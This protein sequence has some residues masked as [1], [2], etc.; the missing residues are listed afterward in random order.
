MR[1]DNEAV[2]EK[3]KSVGMPYDDAFRTMMVK[4]RTLAIPFLNEMFHLSIPSDA[5][6]VAGSNELFTSS[7]SRRI[8][9]SNLRIAGDDTLYHTECESLPGGSRILI[10]LFEYDSSIAIRHA[11]IEGDTLYVTY[12]KTGV[13]YLRNSKSVND[14]MHMVIKAP[15]GDEQLNIDI[16]V[17]KVS[18]YSLEE[19]FDK[20]LW[21]L[22]P[23]SIF[24]HLSGLNSRV[25]HR[26]QETEDAVIRD[27]YLI[28]DEVDKQVEVGSLD[29]FSAGVLTELIS[30]VFSVVGRKSDRIVKGAMRIMGGQVLELEADKI[31]VALDNAYNEGYDEAYDKAYNKA[32]NETRISMAKTFIPVCKKAGLSVTDAVESLVLNSGLT[33]ED[34][35]ALV[36]KYW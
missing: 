17:M 33:Q 10:R 27:L 34:A 14:R 3:R 21:F 6:I 36:K 19:I 4:S 2:S 32:S 24:N 28:R 18:E 12:P 25:S 11:T 7:G 13:L 16:A 35:E 23:F 1:K 15:D 30:K 20:K 29:V 31:K 5:R 8:T 26:F 9:D 22:L